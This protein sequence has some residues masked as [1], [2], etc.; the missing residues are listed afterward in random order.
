[1]Y[2]KHVNKFINSFSFN[3]LNLSVVCLENFFCDALFKIK[4]V[5]INELS[6]KKLSNFFNA[7]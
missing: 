6:M 5:M 3:N 4:E 1:M 2:F 7:T